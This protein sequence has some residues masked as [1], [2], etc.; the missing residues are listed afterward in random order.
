MTMNHA[1]FVQ[2]L[3]T[4]DKLY[5]L[6]FIAN[7]FNSYNN[8]VCEENAGLLIWEISIYINHVLIRNDNGLLNKNLITMNAVCFDLSLV[9]NMINKMISKFGV[10]EVIGTNFNKFNNQFSVAFL[11]NQRVEFSINQIMNSSTPL[12]KSTTIKT[13]ENLIDECDKSDKHSTCILYDLINRFNVSN[14]LIN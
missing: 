9:K 8:V 1:N 2:M 11:W 4:F 12:V 3:K 6:E 14:N 5:C 10:D 7:L 13:I